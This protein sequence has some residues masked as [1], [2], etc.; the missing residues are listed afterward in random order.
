MRQSY[1]ERP[2]RRELSE[3]VACVWVQQVSQAAPYEH[4][5]APNGCAEIACRIGD[6]HLR[7]LGPRLTAATQTLPPGTVVVGVRLRPGAA[8]SLLAPAC[9]LVDGVFELDALW[10]RAAHVA[11]DRVAAA[12][13]ADAAATIL[14]D[15]LLARSRAAAAPDPAVTEA[16]RRL[17]PWR[18]AGLDHALRDLFLSPRQLRRRFGAALGYGPKTLQ[19]IL[20]FQGFLALAHDEHA[21]STL[22]RLAATAG[23]ADQ[24][25]LSR[26]CVRLTGLTPSSFLADVRRS[27]GATHDHAAS[28]A[29]L[30]GALLAPRSV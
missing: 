14:E 23:Y 2:A 29:P 28:F 9:E 10:G 7:A 24:A 21:P 20:R 6:P 19:R 13:S 11:A 22:A 4:R 27:C 16:V 3:R 15:E 17:Q 26:E 8:P 5:T 12:P 25:H 18:H 1:R 30:R